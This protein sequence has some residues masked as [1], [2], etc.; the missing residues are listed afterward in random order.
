[1]VTKP[2]TRKFSKQRPAKKFVPGTP[3]E[4]DPVLE[5][6]TDEELV[7]DQSLHPRGPRVL[8]RELA[9]RRRSLQPREVAIDVHP[10]PQAGPSRQLDDISE[11]EDVIAGEGP[12]G[13]RA[14]RPQKRRRRRQGNTEPSSG[15]LEELR[16]R[17]PSPGSSG[18]SGSGGRVVVKPAAGTAKFYA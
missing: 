18:S 7:A 15:S 13:P 3:V 8:P 4:E 5:E 17:T 14:Q 16:N 11:D 10:S 9:M 1:M 2:R 6:E 12:S